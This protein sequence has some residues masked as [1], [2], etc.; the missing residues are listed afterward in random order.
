MSMNFRLIVTFCLA[1]LSCAVH[2][3]DAVVPPPPA[4]KSS[5]MR[6]Q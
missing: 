2:A 5:E 4:G 1:L 6:V 3:T